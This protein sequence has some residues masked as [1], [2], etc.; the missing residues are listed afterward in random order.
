MIKFIRCYS[1]YVCKQYLISLNN[2]LLLRDEE[3]IP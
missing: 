1:I 3:M 2:A